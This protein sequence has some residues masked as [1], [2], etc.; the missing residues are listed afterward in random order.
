METIVIPKGESPNLQKM[1]KDF[2]L[3]KQAVYNYDTKTFAKKVDNFERNIKSLVIV[4]ESSQTPNEHTKGKFIRR[5]GKV[6]IYIKSP[7]AQFSISDLQTIVHELNHA[8]NYEEGKRGNIIP[9]PTTDSDYKKY[10]NIMEALN[11]A[12]TQILFSD[13]LKKEDISY[14]SIYGEF[15]GA[16]KIFEESIFD[17][18][19]II[20]NQNGLE[21]LRN[22]DGMDI[23]ELISYV[24]KRTGYSI[25][26]TTQYIDCLGLLHYT[27]KDGY[28][29]FD[30]THNMPILE[31]ATQIVRQQSKGNE[32]SSLQELLDNWLSESIQIKDYVPEYQEIYE[33]SKKFIEGIH[34]YSE[35]ERQINLLKFET[36]QD[37]INEK[38]ISTYYLIAN[39]IDSTNL[40][41]ILELNPNLK[42]VE[43]EEYVKTNPNVSFEFGRINSPDLIASTEFEFSWD[44][45]QENEVKK[46][47]KGKS[48]FSN[49]TTSFLS[50]IRSSFQHHLNLNREKGDEQK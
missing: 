2:C 26:E 19:C 25:E 12:E 35:E 50:N 36:I 34:I 45:R 5:D 27:I 18:L 8:W 42:A 49:V 16:Y 47:L 6:L 43:H 9:I 17:T 29:E 37:R 22:I 32:T 14:N 46:S 30:N 15:C 28:I 10:S 44:F 1:M 7:T 4:D 39:Y 24:S 13:K 33:L 31:K 23:N 38:L 3:A 48:L 11:E 21:F 40:Q 41:N 20:C